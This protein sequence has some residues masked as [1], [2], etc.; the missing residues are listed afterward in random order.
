MQYAGP[1][2]PSPT[3]RAC[4]NS[5]PLSWWSHPTISSSVVP[6]SSC[7]SSP[8]R[9][10]IQCSALES[11]VLTTEPPGKSLKDILGKE[12]LHEESCDGMTVIPKKTWR[13]WVWLEKQFSRCGLQIISI[14]NTWE[15]ARLGNPQDPDF[16]DWKLCLELSKLW[17]YRPSGRFWGIFESHGMKMGAPRSAWGEK[18]ALN[19]RL[20]D[21]CGGPVVKTLHFHC[22]EHGFNP[23]SRK[24]CIWSCCCCC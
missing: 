6:F 11:K 2:C 4:S 12:K 22:R 21:F 1:L 17:C 14:S 16:F 24:F 7:L 19:V 13:N 3:P 15:I 9:D 20:E 5:C 8:T 18:P 23:W 10:Q